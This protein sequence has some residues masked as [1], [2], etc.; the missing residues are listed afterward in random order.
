MWH[1]MHYAL[2]VYVKQYN[3]YI[4]IYIIYI[5]YMYTYI[6]IHIHS[7]HTCIEHGIRHIIAIMT[8]VRRM[9]LILLLTQAVHAVFLLEQ[10]SG[11][12]DTLP[13]HPRLDYL[14]NTVLYALLWHW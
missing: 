3:I 12:V 7:T 2:V 10:P 11:S 9:A 1:N 13:F 5:Y 6:Y 8:F 4:Y 14:F